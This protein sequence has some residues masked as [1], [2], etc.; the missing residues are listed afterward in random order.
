MLSLLG[1]LVGRKASDQRQEEVR[2][3]C[4]EV[5]VP[6]PGDNT[7]MYLCK[8]CNKLVYYID[9]TPSIFKVIPLSLAWLK[10]KQ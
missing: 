1:K 3:T 6:I 9:P 5:A 10:K 2:C 8:K 7:D 4:G